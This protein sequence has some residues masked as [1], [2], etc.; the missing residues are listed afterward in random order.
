M[1][2]IPTSLNNSPAAVDLFWSWF[3]WLLVVI[4]AIFGVALF[5]WLIRWT[6]TKVRQIL[7]TRKT[8]KAEDK[9]V[10][11][12]HL[13]SFMP[14]A[15]IL[16]LPCPHAQEACQEEELEGMHEKEEQQAQ[17]T[18]DEVRIPRALDL[19]TRC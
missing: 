17:S 13:N 9:L 18:N 6:V 16:P 19:S 2:P 11:P 1:A 5:G 10:L 8:R 4:L 3:M 15:V 14:R 7:A 12:T